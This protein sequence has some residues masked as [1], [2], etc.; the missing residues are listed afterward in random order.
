[1]STTG[2][3]VQIEEI[4]LRSSRIDRIP[5]DAE[6][7]QNSI[8]IK[9]S[10]LVNKELIQAHLDIEV[11]AITPSDPLMGVEMECAFV[12]VF[13]VHEGSDREGLK[14]FCE[15]V[16]LGILWPYAREYVNDVTSR[17]GLSIQSLPLI[18]PRELI[19]KL[20]DNDSITVDFADDMINENDEQE[21]LSPLDP[22]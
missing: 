17:M 11:T 13:S 22:S 12:G 3:S 19:P 6:N 8:M 4:V 16:P 18:N 15:T 20:L 14:E 7:P 21:D 2:Y 9:L 5:L 10:S 1:M